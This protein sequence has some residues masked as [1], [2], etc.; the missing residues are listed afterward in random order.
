MAGGAGTVAD[1]D[2]TI[3]A[4]V[5]RN[6]ATL[7]ALA[8]RIRDA[9]DGAGVTF[10]LRFVVDASPDDSWSVVRQLASADARIGGLLLGHNVGQHAAVLAGMASA[11]ARWF[12]VMDADLQDPPEAIPDLVACAR[13]SGV[14]VFAARRGRYERPDRLVTSRLFKTVLCW[15]SGVPVDVG[16]FFVVSGEIAAA[17]CMV[18]VRPP[19]VVV[20]AY[21][22]SRECHTLAVT[23]AT[24]AS[25]TSAYSSLA[26]VRAA[27]RSI[28]CAV[29]CRRASGAAAPRPSLHLP[30][31]AERVNV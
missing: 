4:P 25:G 14:T 3:V 2:I 15:I 26:R 5:Y 16:T 12:V 1:P 17:M 13:Q 31:I 27:V 20:L 10:R 19:Q 30:C 7:P 18:R 11:P 24:R 21:H 9:M 8:A 29:A 23:R 28:S 22:T 6:A